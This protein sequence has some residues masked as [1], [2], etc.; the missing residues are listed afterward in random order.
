MKKNNILLVVILLLVIFLA[1]ILSF[2]YINMDDAIIR[3]VAIYSDNSYSI[4][5]A[6]NKVIETMYYAQGS[7]LKIVI[8]YEFT[9]QKVSNVIMDFYHESNG[10]AKMSYKSSKKSN[11]KSISRNGNVITLSP[12]NP[13]ITGLTE[14]ELIQILEK[15]YE[16]SLYKEIN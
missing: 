16:K 15:K 11:V 13:E 2:V 12:N 10:L 1:L 8:T 5:K 9:S 6:D 7:P 14:D 4:Q 3:E